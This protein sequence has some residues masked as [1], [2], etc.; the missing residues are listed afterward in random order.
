MDCNEN[1]EE[2]TMLLGRTS[3]P[4]M[5]EQNVNG[6]AWK[7]KGIE[8]SSEIG[9]RQTEVKEL[10]I[11]LEGLDWKL[12]ISQCGHYMR[13]WNSQTGCLYHHCSEVSICV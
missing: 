13:Y 12:C 2:G 10:V 1:L 11:D 9:R 3:S 4:L 6:G 5:K 8:E 7:E